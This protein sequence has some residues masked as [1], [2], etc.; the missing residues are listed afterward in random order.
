[1]NRR[2]LFLD[3]DGTVCPEIGYVVRADDLTLLPRSA[4]ALGA[5]RSAGFRR[6]LVTNQSGVA[7][8]LLDEAT[9]RRTHRRLERL[10]ADRG[11]A[12]D[13]IYYCPHHPD[14]GTPA[15]R[16]DCRCRKPQPGML[17]QARDDLGLDL[18]RS[19]VIGDH[20]RDLAAGARV[21]ATPILVLTGHGEREYARRRGRREVEP[22]HVAGDLL[23]AVS[24]ILEREARSGGNLP[25]CP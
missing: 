1:V 22:A 16:R 14:H 5:A 20:E 23:D 18:S 19:Y 21:G 15:Y 25:S 11:A 13:A 10:L 7:R 3:R 24:W 17:E 8:G 9:L 6:V 2:A 12:L 4:E